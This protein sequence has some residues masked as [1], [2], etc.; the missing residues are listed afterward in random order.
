MPA[1]IENFETERYGGF[2]VEHWPIEEENARPY[3][4]RPETPVVWKDTSLFSRRTEAVNDLRKLIA[5]SA[6]ILTCRDDSDEG[7]V[8]YS[9]K[10][11]D[12][13]IAFL[14]PY[15]EWAPAS[16]GVSVPLPRLLPGPSGSIDVHWKNEKKELLVNIPADK[17]VPASF[18]GDDYGKL[19]IKGTLDAASLHLSI[20]MWLLNS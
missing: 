18:Y 8:P 15:T 4:K 14:T 6:A 5:D 11:L 19:F 9:Q 10:T 12:R 16:L 1:I 3:L 13:A 2:S 7:F 20:L 17:S